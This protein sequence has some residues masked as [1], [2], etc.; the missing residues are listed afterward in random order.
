MVA[1]KTEGEKLFER[2][3]ISQGLAFEFEKEYPQKAKRPDYTVPWEGNSVLVDVKDFESPSHLSGSGAFDPYSPIREKINQG[4]TKFKEYKDFCC[5]LALFNNN[6]FVMLQDASI[7]LGSMYGDSGITFPVN[8]ETGVGRADLM[9][10]AFLGRG[11]MVRPHW[12]RPQNTTISAL[13]TVTAIRPHCVRLEEMIGSNIKCKTLMTIEDCEAELRLKDPTYDAELEIPRVIVWHNAAARTP[14]P[15]NLFCGS[16][17]T[18][19]GVAKNEHGSLVQR[20]TFR[21]SGL[22]VSVRL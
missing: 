10:H 5:A 17:D 7:V 16:Y 14:F 11:K 8:I 13:I 2:Y 4:C 22:P 21:G 6:A 3:L 18:H 15:A 19:F 1:A 20:V 9:K 12:S